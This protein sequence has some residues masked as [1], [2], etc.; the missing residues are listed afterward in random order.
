MLIESVAVG[1]DV[2]GLLDRAANVADQAAN[3]EQPAVFAPPVCTFNN[4]RMARSEDVANGVALS[5]EIDACDPAAAQR[6][7]EALL[8][9]VTVAVRSGGEWTDAAGEVHPKTH[10]HWRL[11]EPTVSRPSMTC[12]A[13]RAG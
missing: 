3:V 6:C 2:E 12:S 1:A 10:L 8:G 11:S 5:V 4:P 7:L 9:S 13:K